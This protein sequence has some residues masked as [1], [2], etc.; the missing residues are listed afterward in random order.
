MQ[1]VKLPV[2]VLSIVQWFTLFTNLA[3]SRDI[4]Q[5]IPPDYEKSLRAGY[6]EGPTRV[7]LGLSVISFGHVNEKAMTVTNEIYL[8]CT[9]VDNRLTALH[10]N[11]SHHNRRGRNEGSTPEDESSEKVLQNA[12]FLAGDYYNQ[13]WKPDLYFPDAVEL[14]RPIIEQDDSLQ[15]QV[16]ASGKFLYSMRLIVQTRCRLRM[17][18]F[19]LDQQECPICISHYKYPIEEQSLSWFSNP[20]DMAEDLSTPHFYVDSHVINKTTRYSALGHT[21]INLCAHIKFKRKLTE[22]FIVMYAPSFILTGLSF[23]NFWLDKKAVPARASLSITSILAQITLMT[24]VSLSFPSGSDLK[25]IDVYLMVNFVFTVFTIFEFTIVS[26]AGSEKHI[27]KQKS[28]LKTVNMDNERRATS[29]T[30]SHITSR[31]PKSLKPKSQDIDVVSRYVFSISFIAW[32]IGYFFIV[33][34]LS[35]LMQ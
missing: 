22:Y 26:Y 9:W 29:R 31:L 30:L 23:L 17:T 11:L 6:L 24:G 3:R 8:R 25:I 35:H 19:P 15:L 18:F 28:Q 32:N 20:I 14:K 33:I 12:V 21:Y 13:I 27:Q 34:L 10:A 16:D 4:L 2:Q 7:V 1:L 5:F